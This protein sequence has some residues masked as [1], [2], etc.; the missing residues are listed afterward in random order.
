MWVLTLAPVKHGLLVLQGDFHQEEKI[1][2][3]KFFGKIFVPKLHKWGSI[4]PS[5]GF[6]ID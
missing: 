4:T 6:N 1:V 2:L 3:Y 5:S